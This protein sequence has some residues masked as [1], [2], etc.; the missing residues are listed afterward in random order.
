MHR[1]FR[2]ELLLLAV[3]LTAAC[4]D[5]TPTPGPTPTDPTLI[6]DTFVGTLGPVEFAHAHSFAVPTAGTVTATLVSLTPDSGVAIGLALGTWNG[7]ACT[8][9]ITNDNATPGVTITGIISS[10]GTLCVRVYTV[11]PIPNTETYQVNATHP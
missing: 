2:R 1:I 4:G 6:T 9:L 3:L 8:L 10:A 5:D 11:G 7:A